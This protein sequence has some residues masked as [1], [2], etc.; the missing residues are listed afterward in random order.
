MLQFF[1]ASS[2][3]SLRIPFSP[4]TFTQLSGWVQKHRQAKFVYTYIISFHFILLYFLLH[5]L[6]IS[7]NL[8]F[9]SR[10]LIF[11]NRHR[12]ASNLRTA[13][14]IQDTALHFCKCF[15]YEAHVRERESFSFPQ[16]KW[17]WIFHF[18]H[19][20]CAAPV[21]VYRVVVVCCS[22]SLV[23]LCVATP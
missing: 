18:P 7:F 10:D 15:Q 13:K 3:F 12:L 16:T 11:A 14:T 2:F 23:F 20:T 22:C 21:L 5:F 4:I 8:T 19:Q 17:S 9:M 1:R 6:W